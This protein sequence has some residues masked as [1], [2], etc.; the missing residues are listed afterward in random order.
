MDEAEDICGVMVMPDQKRPHIITD[1]ECNGL[2][3]QS[4]VDRSSMFGTAPSNTKPSM[5]SLCR[6]DHLYEAISFK[7][8]DTM[9]V[10]LRHAEVL[11]NV[12]RFDEITFDESE[13]FFC[14]ES[15]IYECRQ[16]AFKINFWRY[17]EAAD[18]MK[19]LRSFATT[20]MVI[21]HKI[22]VRLSNL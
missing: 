4:H 2:N 6:H 12:S 13:A 11:F 22:K 14:N 17:N 21:F 18:A 10:P 19:V 7:G 1:T 5:L 3:H 8:A 16:R 15:G 9:Y 20:D